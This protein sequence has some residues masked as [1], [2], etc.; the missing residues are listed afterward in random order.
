MSGPKQKDLTGNRYGMITVLGK[1]E[2]RGY[3]Q[4]WLCKCDCGV[5]K[6][7]FGTSLK[8]KGVESCGCLQ[9]KT[10]TTHKASK[11]PLYRTWTNMKS[12]C[13]NPNAQYYD[14]YGGRGI[15]VCDG[16]L[17]FE[18]FKQW[19]ESSGYAKHLTLDR[20][21]N[22]QG[23]SPQNCHWTTRT[24][25][26]RN[27][28]SHKNSTSEYVGVCYCSNK[29][30]WIAAIKINGRSKTIAACATERAAMLT[31]EYYIEEHGLKGFTSNL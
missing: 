20:I 10:V 25:Q 29:Q 21:D 15:T 31:R 17:E 2:K 8:N 18:P 19:A 22:N 23:Y 26:G 16:W 30:K 12:R 14:S 24:M 3:H 6:E 7:I 28:R 1:G 9:L 27:R 13:L 5:E 4:K 11:T